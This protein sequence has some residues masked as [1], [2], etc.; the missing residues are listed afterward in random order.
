VYIFTVKFSNIFYSV[1]NNLDKYYF[2]G[3]PLEKDILRRRCN[4]KNTWKTLLCFQK[5][6][7]YQKKPCPPWN[8]VHTDWARQIK[9][10]LLILLLQSPWANLSTGNTGNTGT[11]CISNKKNQWYKENPKHTLPRTTHPLSPL[12]QSLCFTTRSCLW[13]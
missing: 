9:K 5:Q 2:I 10:P 7:N 13:F 11:G 1:V 8:C 12:I 6:R 3:L 4:N